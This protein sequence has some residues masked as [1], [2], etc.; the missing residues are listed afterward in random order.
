M[1][2]RQRRRPCRPF[3]P[4][5]QCYG[6]FGVLY[7]V[8][9]YPGWWVVGGEAYGNYGHWLDSWNIDISERFA[10][11]SARLYRAPV[12]DKAQLFLAQISLNDEW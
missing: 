4:G 7:V 1:N 10:F 9:R 5:G 12:V 3:R 6:T 11:N 8:Q 2:L